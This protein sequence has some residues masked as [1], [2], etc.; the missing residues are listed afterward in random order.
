MNDAAFARRLERQWNQLR[1][2]INRLADTYDMPG[3]N[4][5]GW[6][7]NGGRNNGGGV[8]DGGSWNG[9]GRQGNV[10]SWAEG[11]FYARNP[12]TG[13][14]ITMTVERN[15]SVMIDFGG[16]NRGNATINGT[17]LV[18]GS[19][20]NDVT[21]I[22]NGFRTTNISTG[23]YIDYYRTPI[24]GGIVGPGVVGSGGVP[25]W[26]IGTFYARNPR[27]GG[28][29]TMNVERNGIVMID[30]GD[31][32]RGNATINGTRLVFDSYVNDVTR[33]NNGF[34]TTNIATGE[35]IDYYRNRPF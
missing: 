33:I 14:V 3:L 27:T 30:F 19:Y 22:N 2:D 13:G 12:Q 5:G 24:N 34:R 20:V 7:G 6:N 23:E 16:G 29:I 26:A 21:R 25:S 9:G 1:R 32:N 10:P 31:G 4:G 18:F 28:V 15:G 11:T 8:N 35:F 17:R